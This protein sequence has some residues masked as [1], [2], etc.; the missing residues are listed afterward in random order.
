MQTI[1][2]VH[3][4]AGVWGGGLRKNAPSNLPCSVNCLN[5][6]LKCANEHKADTEK[7]KYSS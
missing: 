4:G 3:I 1:G 5:L 7:H 2:C 6:Q